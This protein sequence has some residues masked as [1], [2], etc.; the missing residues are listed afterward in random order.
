MTLNLFYFLSFL[1]V[2]SALL[3]VF[4]KNPVHSVLYLIITFFVIAAHYVLLNAQF[5]AIVHIIVYAGAIMVLF[6][7][8]IMLLNLNQE[9]EP[10]KTNLIRFAATISSGLLLIILVGS[11]K[12]TDQMIAQTSSPVEVGLVKSLGRVLF[13]EFLL[14]FEISSV[15]LLAAMVGAVMLGKPDHIKK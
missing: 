2:L 4:S 6:L 8:V 9:A 7:Y 12:G 13:K 11:L 3:V 1:G 14:P 10:H 15:L 5:L